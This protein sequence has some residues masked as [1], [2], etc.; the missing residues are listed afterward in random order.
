MKFLLQYLKDYKK[1]SILAPLFKMCEAVFELLVPLVMAAIIDQGIA[2][3]DTSYVIRMCIV[4]VVLAV[5]GLIFAVTAQYFAAKA[6]IFSAAK[7]RKDLFCHV[8]DMSAA[9]HESMGTSALTTRITSDINQIQNGV[10]MFLRLFLRSPFIV[11]GAM[12]MALIVDVKATLIFVGVI[13]ALAVVVYAVMKSTLPIFSGIQRKMEKIFLAVGENL[14]GAR[15]IRAF[16]NQEEESAAFADSTQA[17]YGDQMKAGRVSALLNPVTYVIVN[18][19]IVV[20][21]WFGSTQVNQGVLAKGE[22]VALV[23]YMS[24]ILVELIK[25][26]NLI[27]LLM[28][29]VPSIGR[30]QQVMELQAD[31][32]IYTDKEVE[33]TSTQGA[34]AVEYQDVSFC[35]PDGSEPALSHLSLTVSR[36]STVGIIGGTGSGKST[37]LQLLYHRYDVTE[38]QIRINGQ[39]VRSYTQ[40]ELSKRIGVVPQKAVLFHGTIRDNLK[41]GREDVTQEMLEEAATAAQADNVI[42]AKQD[43]WDEEV[44]QDAMNFSGGQRQRLTIARALAGRPQILLLDDSASALDV[45]TDAALRKAIRDLTWQPT[46][47]IISQRASSVMDADWIVVLEDGVCV[48]SGT[49]ETLLRDNEVYQ[50]IYYSQFPKEGQQ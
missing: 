16:G 49:H 3:G 17:L 27:V 12:V 6:A 26:A 30:V 10:N 14:E 28:R 24:Q 31:E 34:P 38:G 35:Y 23:N 45:A 20:I 43:G 7:M 9:S 18:L 50:E 5:V 39:D 19:G 33:G 15:V 36:H 13:A 37:L 21:L 41:M 46:V 11:L 25:L 2:D 29:A 48:G 4:L 47:F 8:M 42:A 22:V 1:E 32:R 40:E 44:L